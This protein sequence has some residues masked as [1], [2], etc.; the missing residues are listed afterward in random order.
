MSE[1]RAPG[2]LWVDVAGTT[3]TEA[4]RSLL[5]HPDVGG[6]ILFTANYRDPVQLASLTEA[7]RQVDPELLVIADTEGGRVQRFRDG[8]TGLPPMRALGRAYARDA[9]WTLGAA[10]E[11]GWLLGAELLAVGV[12][13]P[14]APVVDV[15]AAV[16][17]VIG[18]RALSDDP[19]AVAEL[20][21][22]LIKGLRSGGMVATAKHFP[23]H[24]AV[25]ADSHHEL[26]VDER[27]QAALAS[28]LFIY[29]RL[30]ADGL[31][32][33]MPAHV[34]YPAFDDTPASLSSTWL[35][36]W[37]RGRL[38]FTGAVISDDLAMAGAAP[39]GMPSARAHAALAAGCDFLPL[40]H[41]RASVEVAVQTIA[42]TDTGAAAVRRAEFSA[43]VRA[44]QA[45]A[46]RLDSDA[47][48]ERADQAR[49][50]AAALIDET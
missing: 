11:I 7:I 20:A 27:S 42:E 46:I 41:D 24:G 21:W 26:P 33:V 10:E 45:G 38:G 29:E 17:A 37:L 8:F 16:S 40:C 13:V 43:H 47:G 49:S 35:G 18:E 30:I 3:L 50:L 15:A 1:P 19:E 9:Q 6:V 44:R 25:T 48:R 5:A 34:R 22:A 28:E 2:A 32:S 4:D 23:G 31:E 12:D 14:L 36:E 39:G